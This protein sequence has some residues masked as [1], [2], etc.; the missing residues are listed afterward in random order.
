MIYKLQQKGIFLY[1]ITI[2]VSQ[3]KLKILKFAS[4][5]CSWKEL[6]FVKI[7][8]DIFVRLNVGEIF[9]RYKFIANENISL[10][11]ERKFY[12]EGLIGCFLKYLTK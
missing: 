1:L 12:L 11:K 10:Y 7:L 5:Q 4:L 9:V 2:F 8:T 3:V 6:G